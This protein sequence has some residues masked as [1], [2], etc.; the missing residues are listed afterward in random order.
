M[1]SLTLREGRF[2]R[3]FENRKLRQIFGPKRDENGK[4][5][6]LYNEELHSLFLLPN[7]VRAIKHRRL[8]CA[9]LVS[10]MEEGRSAFSILIVIPTGKRPLGRPSVDVWTILE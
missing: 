8:R 9:G 4:W 5:R 10:R 6:R 3:V 7:T 2:R 1:Q